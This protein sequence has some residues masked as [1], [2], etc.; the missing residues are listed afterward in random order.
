M[1]TSARGVRG[2]DLEEGKRLKWA[3]SLT[4]KVMSDVKVAP[5]SLEGVV[6]LGPFPSSLIQLFL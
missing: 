6:A 5:I 1:S 4:S 3:Q 2:W